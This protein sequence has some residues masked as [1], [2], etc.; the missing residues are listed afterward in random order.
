[1]QKDNFYAL[2]LKKSEINYTALLKDLKKK[3]VDNLK[4]VST[5]EEVWIAAQEMDFNVY[6]FD[7]SY[8]ENM[9]NNSMAFAMYQKYIAKL[10]LFGSFVQ[11]V[12]TKNGIK[13]INPKCFY[14][15]P[16]GWGDD[17]PDLFQYDMGY[18][19]EKQN[20]DEPLKNGDLYKLEDSFFIKTNHS[21]VK[22]QLIDVLCLQ[23][24]RNYVTIYV[25][26]SKYL[27]RRTLQA[28]LD[29][30]PNDFVRI[31]RSTVVNAEKIDKVLGN[32]IYI[33][34]LKEFNPIISG[35]YKKQILDVIPIF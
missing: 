6:F 22:L 30:L 28:V 24:E 23:S 7:S 1:M 31:N 3:G 21:L 18:L 16:T 2:V 34:G 8:I 4:V 32:R 27:I 11:W 17:L 10:I 13:P 15:K 33:R 12:E 9:K 25:A 35:T 14:L 20:D 5:L 29:L 19:N 26:N